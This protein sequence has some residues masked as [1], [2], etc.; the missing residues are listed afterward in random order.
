MKAYY[1]TTHGEG[2]GLPIFEAAYSG[3]PVIATDWSGHLDF[4]S[5]THKGKSKKLFARIA[6]D[7]KEVQEAAIWGDLII[8]E[9]RWAFPTDVSIRS[10]LSKVY[11]DHGMYNSWAKSLKESLMK[12]HKL[13]NILDQYITSIFGKKTEEEKK[14]DEDLNE[15]EVC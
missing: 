10:Q 6:Y 2:Y 7:L 8:K 5:G 11:K 12:S 4:L 9:S 13:E 14:W 1:T 3:L 15:V